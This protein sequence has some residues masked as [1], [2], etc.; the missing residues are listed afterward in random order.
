MNSTN[1]ANLHSTNYFSFSKSAFSCNAVVR[2]PSCFTYMTT[3]WMRLRGDDTSWWRGF[4]RRY[5]LLHCR[6]RT[7]LQSEATWWNLSGMILVFINASAWSQVEVGRAWGL[8]NIASKCAKKG[9]F[10]KILPQKW[11]TLAIPKASLAW[12]LSAQTV[13]ALC[14]T[15]LGT[16]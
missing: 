4:S 13:S 7:S 14:H 15:V 5:H 6:R 9:R 1:L 2:F 16:W 3:L 12:P 10:V 8:N 11:Q